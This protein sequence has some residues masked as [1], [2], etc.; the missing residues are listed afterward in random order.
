MNELQLKDKI[1]K[2]MI[3]NE[4][5]YVIQRSIKMVQFYVGICISTE[6]HL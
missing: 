2:C 4:Q 1:I 5:W 3:Q 6:N